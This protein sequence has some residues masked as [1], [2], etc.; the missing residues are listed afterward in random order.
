M[1]I[2]VQHTATFKNVTLKKIRE[3]DK[4]ETSLTDRVSS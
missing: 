4:T 2:Y 1:F 3:I